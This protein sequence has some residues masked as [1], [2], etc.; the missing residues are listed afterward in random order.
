[1]PFGTGT[2]GDW[3]CHVI[4]PSFWALDLGAPS[5]VR[6]EVTDY[7]PSKHALTYPPGTKITFEFPAKGKRGPVK[8]VWHDGAN[9]IPR[10][11]GLP[12]DEKLP[13]VGAVLLGQ[14]GMIV[15]GSH[16][17]GGCR[18]LPDTLMDQHS[19]TN[20]PPETIRRVKNHA[21]DWIDAVRTGRQA[22][23]EFGYGGPL[24]QAALLGAIAIRFPGDT[25]QWDDAAAR[26]TNHPA[27]NAFVN[28]PYRDGWKL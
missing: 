13:G 10:P 21:W 24:T 20:A 28:P 1:M 5:T 15:H 27:A 16:G 2:V 19:G 22:G 23:S 3:F 11:P 25:L 6:A 17:G 7:D 18:I 4:D 26:F 9:P 14:K 8:L 12:A